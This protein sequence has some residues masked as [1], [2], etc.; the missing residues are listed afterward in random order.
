MYDRHLDAFIQAA[1][2]GSFLKAAN[3]LYISANALTKQ[4]NLLES[5]LGVKLFHRSTQGIVL[6]PA[7]KLIYDEAQKMIHH[8]GTILRKAR[9]LETQKEFV[10]HLGVSLMNP[11]KVLLEQWN[12]ASVRYP[13][14]R[15][16]IVPF[17]D[18]VPAFND[19]LDHLGQKVDLISCPYQTTYWGDRYSS[20]HLKELPMCIAC[21]NTHRLADKDRLTISDLRNETLIIAKR[22][23]SASSD[24]VR[25]ELE[26]YHPQIRLKDVEYLDINMFNRLASSDELILSVECWKDVHPLLVTLPVD[27]D[28]QLSYGLIYVKDPPREVLQF[29]MA[30][31]NVDI[32]APQHL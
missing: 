11:A 4:V 25:D 17:E 10:I 3:K 12:K 29:I 18:T 8:S 22:G 9:D 31:G 7:G 19:V 32:P 14:I 1:D 30:I 27:W 26:Q 13:N 23:I 2:S 28:Y 20:F 24:R 6:T 5:H 15:L 16:E 21:S